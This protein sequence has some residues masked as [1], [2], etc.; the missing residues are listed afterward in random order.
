MTAS[1]ICAPIQATPSG[2]TAA[3]KVKPARVMLSGLLVLQTSASARRL[4]SNTLA[5]LRRQPR[6]S[7]A[8]PSGAWGELPSCGDAPLLGRLIGLVLD[9]ALM[10][11][12][13]GL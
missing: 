9:W 11:S 6:L 12:P 13:C 10:K 7:G 2:R 1:T 8:A 5:R 4:Y 3:I